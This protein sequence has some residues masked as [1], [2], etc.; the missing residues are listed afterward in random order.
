MRVRRWTPMEKCSSASG[1]STIHQPSPVA[2]RE[3]NPKRRWNCGRSVYSVRMKWNSAPVGNSGR[4][5]S[6]PWR[7]P[8]PNR[9]ASAATAAT[10]TV[11]EITPRRMRPLLPRQPLPYGRGSESA[12][13]PRPGYPLGRERLALLFLNKSLRQVETVDCAGGIAEVLGVYAR[14]IHPTEVEIEPGSFLAIDHAAAG[15]D[16]DRKSTRLNSS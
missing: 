5:P 12:S 16:G 9:W 7:M 6:S 15:L 10:R 13:E 1:Q 2:P 3:A 14:A 11:A 8:P 4:G